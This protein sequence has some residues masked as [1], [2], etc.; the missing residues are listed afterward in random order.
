MWRFWGADPRSWCECLS[1]L[2]DH[3]HPEVLLR[4]YR[5]PE[6]GQKMGKGSM[7]RVIFSTTKQVCNSQQTLTGCPTAEFLHC[8]PRH[9]NRSHRLRTQ[10]L[11]TAPNSELSSGCDVCFWP[12]SCRTALKAQGNITY[13]YP[14]IKKNIIGTSLVAQWLGLLTSNTEDAGSIPGQGTNIPRASRDDQK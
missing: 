10:S 4:S 14:F 2:S 3:E 12:T 9:S 6:R 11:K 5:V 13:I 7:L 8:L 1:F